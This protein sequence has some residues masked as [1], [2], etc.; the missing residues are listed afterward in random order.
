MSLFVANWIRHTINNQAMTPLDSS[1]S[2]GY[3]FSEH[4]VQFLKEACH[5]LGNTKGIGVSIGFGSAEGYA[6]A[7]IYVELTLGAEH[8]P[9]V[10]IQSAPS[11]DGKVWFGALAHGGTTPLGHQAG[12]DTLEEA[13]SY[14]TM[15]VASV[16]EAHKKKHAKEAFSDNAVDSKVLQPWEIQ[17]VQNYAEKIGH[18]AREAGWADFKADLDKN[19]LSI[20]LGYVRNGKPVP[21]GSVVITLNSE[22][23]TL[24]ST[25]GFDGV[26]ALPGPQYYA[27]VSEALTN[28]WRYFEFMAKKTS[29]HLNKPWW[30]KLF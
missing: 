30:K 12:Y 9:V 29:S 21:L 7:L 13:T 20:A 25:R 23:K 2:T 10:L 5:T 15:F 11:D 27:S 4:Q 16:L 26:S 14:G 6:A 1:A 24:C 28:A 22:G 18:V 8:S 19:A 3:Q 17:F